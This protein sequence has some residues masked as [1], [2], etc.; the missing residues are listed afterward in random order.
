MSDTQDLQAPPTLPDRAREDTAAILSR[1]RFLIQSAGAGI[2]AAG[3]D[4]GGKADRSGGTTPDPM[5]PPH[6]PGICLSVDITPD[7]K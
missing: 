4:K 5:E 3:C 2:G 1:Q 7:R 6:K